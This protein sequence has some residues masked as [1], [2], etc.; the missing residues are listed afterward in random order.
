MSDARCRGNGRR[1]G[2]GRYFKNGGEKNHY[3]PIDS[4]AEAGPAFAFTIC[5]KNSDA[6]RKSKGISKPAYSV[7]ENQNKINQILF[8]IL[9][10]VQIHIIR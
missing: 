10:V 7:L 3:A 6:M 4:N 8:L 5:L 2:D 9:C 1:R